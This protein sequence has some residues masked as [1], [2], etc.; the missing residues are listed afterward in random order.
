M[1]GKVVNLQLSIINYQLIIFS[2][3]EFN[4]YIKKKI[5]LIILVGLVLFFWPKKYYEWDSITKLSSVNC[6]CLGAKGYI[7]TSYNQ[8]YSRGHKRGMCYGLLNNCGQ[9]SEEEIEIINY[10]NKLEDFAAGKHTN[11]GGG[12]VTDGKEIGNC[13]MV[14]GVDNSG[15]GEI[16]KLIDKVD[17]ESFEVLGTGYARDENN[18]YNWIDVIDGADPKTFKV[19]ENNK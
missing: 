15:G 19:P 14:G 5:I 17:I 7:E 9:R 13:V 10:N 3:V 6:D 8:N 4:M 2:K 1:Q 11:L 16:C 12:Y 18:V